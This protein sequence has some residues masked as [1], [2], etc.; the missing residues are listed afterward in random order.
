MDYFHNV[1]MCKN[2]QNKITMKS[3]LVYGLSN[4]R[5]GVESI[6]LSIMSCLPECK[7]DILLSEGSCAYEEL[8]NSNV[9]RI[10]IASWGR[11]PQKF[12]ADLESV[13]NNR[14]YDYVWINGCLMA[15]RSIISVVRKYSNAKIITHSHGTSFEEGSAIKSVILK[16]LHYVNR[17]FY[18]ENT[19]FPC[20]CSLK[21]AEW[22]YGKNFCKKQKVFV[23]NNGVDVERF[24]FNKTT[25]DTLR[26]E[27]AA[28]DSFV[29]FHAGRLTHV[30]NQ[31][32]ILEITKSLINSGKNVKLWIAGVGELEEHLKQYASELGISSMV[33]FLGFRNDVSSLCQAADAFLL[34]S[35]HE[36][37]PVTIIEAQ[38]TGLSCFVSDRVTREADVSGLVDFIPIEKSSDEWAGEINNF[39]YM[40]DREAATSLIKSKRFD[41]D[42]VAEDFFKFITAI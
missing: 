14:I 31:T 26:A 23:V 29:L 9:N 25:R 42:S 10:N 41:L 20:C 12:K 3:F 7:F 36:G 1:D 38:A 2:H 6:V 13:L 33:S 39:K 15:N 11:S 34:P 40:S 35:F 17:P 28:G 4:G 24:Q 27:L 16:I 18:L 30:K 37:L 8:F 19:D 22:Y 5:G 21:S 32:K